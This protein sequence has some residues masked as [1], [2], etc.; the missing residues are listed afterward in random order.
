MYY[1]LC[2]RL[3][4]GVYAYLYYYRRDLINI[5]VVRTEITDA[6]LVEKVLVKFGLGNV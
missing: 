6:T 2:Q 1:L 4:P 5:S 3:E